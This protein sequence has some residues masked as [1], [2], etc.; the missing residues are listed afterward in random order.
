[1]TDLEKIRMEISDIDA[2]SQEVCG[3]MAAVARLALA[4]LETPEGIMDI[5][6]IARALSLIQEKA[7]ALSNDIN[8]SAE[9]LGA[10]YTDEGVA[11]R[12]Q[13]WVEATGR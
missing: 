7:S 5:D 2:L 3:Q 11:R 10:A 8:C 4:S 13:A 12:Y 6:V 9:R 1:M